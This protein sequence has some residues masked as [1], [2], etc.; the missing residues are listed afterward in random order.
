MKKKIIALCFVLCVNWALF[1]QTQ[2]NYNWESSPI[3]YKLSNEDANLSALV[4]KDKRILEYFY[5]KEELFKLKIIHKIAR[6]NDDIALES[7]NKVFVPLDNDAQLIQIKARSISPNGTITELNKENIKELKNVEEY[8]SFKIFAIEGATKGGYIEYFYVLKS[9]DD[10]Y[11][12]REIFQTDI[13]TKEATFELFYPANLTFIA[14]GYNGFNTFNTETTKNITKIYTTINDL[15]AVRDEKYASTRANLIKVEY[16]LNSVKVEN[17]EKELYNWE[18]AAETFGSSI[19]YNNENANKAIQKLF[20]T[21]KLKKLKSEEAKINAIEQYIKANIALNDG[22]GADFTLPE[23]ILSNK[24][25]NDIGLARLYAACFKQ[26]NINNQAVITSNRFNTLLDKDFPCWANLSDVIF[27][28]PSLNKYL[29]PA[30]IEY[31]LGIPPYEFA[32]NYG[33]FIKNEK[34]PEV[35]L[36]NMPKAQVSQDNLDANLI[37]DADFNVLLNVKH[38]WTGYRAFPLRIINQMQQKE[39]VDQ[40]LLQGYEGA[41]MKSSKVIN[42]NINLNASPQTEFAIE[43]VLI[44]NSLIEKAGNAFLLKIGDVIGPQTELYQDHKRQQ[45]VDM[46]YPVLYKRTI[47]FEIPNGY[48]IKNLNDINIDVFQEDEKGNKYNRFV[49]TYTQTGNKVT[50][51]I[52]EYYETIN[53]QNSDYENFRKVINAAADFNKVIF[54]IEK[55]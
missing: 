48:T 32:S 39:L 23:K 15:E 42:E 40:T 9:I 36:I 30:K 18:M 54:I 1:A 24:Y 28:F 17:T 50:V 37:F 29:S 49:S 27:Y 20:K 44:A 43:G 35:K 19:Y 6:V 13:K 25:A 46:Q 22:H 10:Q 33:L 16:K 12:G 21:L 14:K 5:E 53:L 2:L 51:N 11:Y 47:I 38:S 3:N 4:I 41:T 31:R 26:A 55:N 8:G 52:N 7:F 34:Y 45:P